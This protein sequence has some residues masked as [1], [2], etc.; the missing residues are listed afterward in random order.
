ML[1]KIDIIG[2]VIAAVFILWIVAPAGLVAFALEK[3]GKAAGSN[4]C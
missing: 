3:M 4:E 1:G 2:W